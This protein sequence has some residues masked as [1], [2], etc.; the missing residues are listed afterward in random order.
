MKNSNVE[1][2]RGAP[3]KAILKLAWPIMISMLLTASY[4]IID[5]I[6]VAGLGQIAIA[7]IGFVSP[8]FMILNGTSV[9]LGIG[10]TSLI[11]RYIGAR[12]K[13]KASN[14]ATHSILIFL[15]ASILLTVVLLIVQK[16]VLMAYGANGK[17]LTEAL[18]YSTVLFTGL[19]T[20]M[21]SNGCSGILRG[22]GDMK[23]AMYAIVVSVIMN[24]I[25]DPIFIYGIRLG[26]AGASLATIVSAFCA[27]IVILYWILIKKN[28]YVTVTFHNFKY[29]S[30]MIKDMLAVGIPSSLEMFIMSIAAA[31]YLSFITSIGG[32]YGVAAYSSGIRLYLFVI[33]PLTAIGSAVVAVSGSA[34]GAKNGDYLSRSHIFGSKF[35]VILGVVMII[36]FLLFSNQL[37]MLFAYTSETANLVP[38]IANFLRIATLS[39]AFT[40]AGLV[41]GSLYQ[42]LGKGTYSLFFTLLREVII[43]VPLTYFFG[44]YMGYGLTGIWMGLAI[45]RSIASFIT[46]ICA[47]YVINTVKK[48]WTQ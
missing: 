20:F 13:E 33:M 4:N 1:L 35:G 2:M 6:W 24:A 3:E 22:E 11:S 31:L 25:L 46:F 34:F 10:A 38:E 43:T 16:P 48:S 9:G 32:A 19:F 41:S 44:I 18:K 8:L 40:G 29:N 30:K 45:G 5:G 23:R 26:S 37:A 47:R 36:I 42:G 17:T 28:T 12:N 21:F 14:A 7:G 39:L 15:V 27:S